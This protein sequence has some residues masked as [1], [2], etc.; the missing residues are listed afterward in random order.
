M[1]SFELSFTTTQPLR[2]QNQLGKRWCSAAGSF[3]DDLQSMPLRATVPTSCMRGWSFFGLKTGL[4]FGPWYVLNV[5]SLRCSALHAEQISSKCSHVFA[6][7]LL[8]CVLVKK[9]EPW[10]PPETRHQFQS[11]N[12]LFMRSRASI[13]LIQSHQQQYQIQFQLCSCLKLLSRSHL[14]FG[15]CPGSVKQDL[16]VCV[17][18]TGMILAPWQET[19]T[20][21]CK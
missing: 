21:L 6:K 8:W 1:P 12:K 9:E 11:P 15:K 17:L 13:P 18:S 5:M 14:R 3:W 4:P 16:S 10:Q 2:P 7:L 20:C 19:V